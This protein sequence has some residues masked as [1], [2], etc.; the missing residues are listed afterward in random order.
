MI[1]TSIGPVSTYLSQPFKTL[2][3]DSTI[4]YGYYFNEDEWQNVD[5]A[6]DFEG[7]IITV[8]VSDLDWENVEG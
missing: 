3:K 6:V 4:H 2:L 7:E 1:K 5:Y 8:Y